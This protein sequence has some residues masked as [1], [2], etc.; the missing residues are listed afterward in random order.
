M[1]IYGGKDP[2]AV[3]GFILDLPCRLRWARYYHE[4]VYAFDVLSLP[5]EEAAEELTLMEQVIRTIIPRMIYYEFPS[6]PRVQDTL[7]P[8][9]PEPGATQVQYVFALRDNSSKESKTVPLRNSDI[10][11]V[12]LRLGLGDQKPKWYEMYRYVC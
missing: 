11:R 9:D 1:R 6:L 5:T 10:Q 2:T 4:Q 8:I 7:L 12:R 3:Y